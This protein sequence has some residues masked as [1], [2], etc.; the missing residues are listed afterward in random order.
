[1]TDERAKYDAPRVDP[2]EIRLALVRAVLQNKVEYTVAEV[3]AECDQLALI[4][5]KGKADK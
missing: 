5:F 4:D 1:M 3:V 2:R